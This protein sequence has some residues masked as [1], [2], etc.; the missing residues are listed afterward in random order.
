MTIQFIKKNGRKVFAVLNY[1]DYVRM[2]R[3]L[4]N[5]ARLQMQDKANTFAHIRL[6]RPLLKSN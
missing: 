4:K 5:Y 3:K 2:Q 6:N 1:A